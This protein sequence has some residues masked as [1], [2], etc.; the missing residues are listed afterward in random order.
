MYIRTCTHTNSPRRL[1][2]S[3]KKALELPPTTWTSCP[4]HHSINHTHFLRPNIT[5]AVYV[6]PPT[7]QPRHGK[8]ITW[9]VSVTEPATWQ[10]QQHQAKLTQ[11]L[12]QWR[13]TGSRRQSSVTRSPI[14]QSTL[15]TRNLL[16]VIPYGPF[17]P[18]VAAF[19]LQERSCRSPQRP[20]SPMVQFI[21]S[22]AANL[23]IS[24]GSYARVIRTHFGG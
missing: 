16:C 1:F 5:H 20:L 10:V 11:C 9:G 17:S 23:I 2:C 6:A 22:H 3:D 19:S 21:K 14:I 8:P 4:F 7:F 18:R 15:H 13:L 12:L 24:S